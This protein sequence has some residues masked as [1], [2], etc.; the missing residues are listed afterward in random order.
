MSDGSTRSC[1]P[2]RVIVSGS[3]WEVSGKKKFNGCYLSSRE[4]S[5]ELTLP[6]F[7]LPAPC[8]KQIMYTDVVINSQRGLGK[9]FYV[10]CIMYD[11]D[12]L[13]QKKK[14]I[15]PCLTWMPKMF[16]SEPNVSVHPDPEPEPP[17]RFG[18]EDLVEPNPEQ[19]FRFV[20]EHCLEC[21]E[22]DR[23]QSIRSRPREKLEKAVGLNATP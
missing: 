4:A 11:L 16:G 12:F 9:W 10:A 6:F 1:S 22:P 23:G 19:K 13:Y 7:R 8:H 3:D 20:F 15:M 14:R 21:S 17:F 2:P 18:F 5:I